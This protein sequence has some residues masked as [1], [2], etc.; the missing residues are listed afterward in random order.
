M[1][2]EPYGTLQAVKVPRKVDGSGKGFGFVLFEKPEEAQRALAM[3][4]TAFK[5]RIL[6]VKLSSIVPVKP[7]ATT[8]VSH[9]PTGEKPAK[10]EQGESKA[11]EDK[12]TGVVKPD[13]PPP[14]RTIAL[15]N[16]P[17]TVNDARIRVLA[18]QYGPL[19]KV[20]VRPDH[21]GAKIEFANEPDAGRAALALDGTVLDGQTIRVGSVSD[22]LA[23]QPPEEIAPAA[24]QPAKDKGAKQKGKRGGEASPPA[25]V[26]PTAP[27]GQSAMPIRRPGAG[28]GRRGG[29]GTKRARPT[30]APAAG[31]PQQ[32]P[33]T[34][35]PAA[36]SDGA[37]GKKSNSDFKALVEQSRRAA[38]PE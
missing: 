11:P 34:A 14:A 20:T 3:E 10:P 32:A 9:V 2:F 35:G 37:A 13:A 23:Q 21:A 4:G 6:H 26:G 31:R 28:G 12:D 1:L 7:A 17:D 18:E 27:F 16:V 38:P 22:M 19:I 33:V 5:D 30:A 24:A 29:L 25:P 8:I 15:M 36:E